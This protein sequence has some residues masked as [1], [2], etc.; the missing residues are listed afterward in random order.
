[1]ST[2]RPM[3]LIL[4]MPFDQYL[5]VEAFSNSDM[6]L[7]ARSAWHWKNRVPVKVTRLRSC[8]STS[9]CGKSTPSTR[10]HY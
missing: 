4:D 1:M 10:T 5:A 7:L 3:G 9:S 8:A 2:D 6:R